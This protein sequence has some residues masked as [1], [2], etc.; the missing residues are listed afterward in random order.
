MRGRESSPLLEVVA[1]P[2]AYRL[3]P[4]ACCIALALV[5]QL[6]P[7]LGAALIFDRAAVGAGEYWRIATASLVH[8]SW[9]HLAGDTLVLVV[10]GWLLEERHAAEIAALLVG[11]SVASGLAVL[12]FAPELRWYG[13]LSGIAH[14]AVVYVA[15]L[16]VRGGGRRRAL[17]CL[18]LIII[19]TKL[20]SDAG[21]VR[22]IDASHLGAPVTVANVS[23]LGAVAYALGLCACVTM[24]AR[25]HERPRDAGRA[26]TVADHAEGDGAG[27][28]GAGDPH[29]RADV[30]AQHRGRIDDRMLGVI[31]GRD[32]R[33]TAVA[34]DQRA[35]DRRD[36]VHGADE[37]AVD[38]HPL[39][40]VALAGDPDIDAAQ[41]TKYR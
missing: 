36:T 34:R 32:D 30:R 41:P 11:A 37:E 38:S 13:G 33:V 20:A 15:L 12:A 24:W 25:A 31:R 3:P 7:A 2:T 23:H 22:L 5:V 1:V 9:A 39:G 40:A 21:R 19:A 27:F 10:A 18:A 8:F 4:T 14:A 29:P 28:Q 26:L 17:S 16:G 6:S 35:I